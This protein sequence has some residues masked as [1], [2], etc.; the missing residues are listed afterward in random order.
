MCDKLYLSYIYHDH[1]TF[2][3]LLLLDL[4]EKSQNKACEHLQIMDILKWSHPAED[5]SL[6]LPTIYNLSKFDFAPPLTWKCSHVGI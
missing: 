5:T 1:D 4:S 2:H 6:P 3:C